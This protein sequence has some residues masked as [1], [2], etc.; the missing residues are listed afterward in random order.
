M[1]HSCHNRNVE[2]ENY[3]E[4]RLEFLDSFFKDVGMKNNVSY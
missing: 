4:L 2:G 3:Q 1:Y